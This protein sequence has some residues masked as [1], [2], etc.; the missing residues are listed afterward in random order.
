MTHDGDKMSAWL[1]EAADELDKAHA[2]LDAYG[3]PRS[4][5][6]SL[7]GDGETECTLAARIAV[8]LTGDVSA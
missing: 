2:I 8:A 5:P 3:V 7:G 1:R 6:R 4:L